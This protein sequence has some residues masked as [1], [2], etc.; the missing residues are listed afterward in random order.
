MHAFNTS[1]QHCNPVSHEA[2]NWVNFGQEQKLL[3]NPP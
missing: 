3:I 2:A 1:I